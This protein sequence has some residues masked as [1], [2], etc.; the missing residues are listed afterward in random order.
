VWC[1]GRNGLGQIDRL[2]PEAVPAPRRIALPVAATQI[3]A[4]DNFTCARTVDERAW[5]WGYNS[6]GQIEATDGKTAPAVSSLDQIVRIAAGELHTC[7]LRRDSSVWCWGYDL[8]GRLGRDGD[9]HDPLPVPGVFATD[10]AA[11]S[12]TCAVVRAGR[13]TCWGNDGDG[14]LGDGKVA[15]SHQ[16]RRSRVQRR[17]RSAVLLGR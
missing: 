14:A 1:W 8:N 13:F 6:H 16:E 17:W 5:C 12:W 3:S 10:L 7:A 11:A 9:L 15:T 4:G 2:G